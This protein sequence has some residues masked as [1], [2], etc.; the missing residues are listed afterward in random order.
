M[1]NWEKG[2]KGCIRKEQNCF[3]PWILLSPAHSI[4]Q[5]L[6]LNEL[7]HVNHLEKFWAYNK[8]S[9]Y[10][11]YYNYH[12]VTQV[13]QSE[14]HPNLLENSEVASLTFLPFTCS[15][16]LL[17]FSS[18]LMQLFPLFLL[19]NLGCTHLTWARVLLPPLPLIVSVLMELTLH[20]FGSETE[21]FKSELC[22]HSCAVLDFTQHHFSIL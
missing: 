3:L 13:L 1:K 5:L 8:Y 11:Y 21:R 7:V 10:I 20:R 14:V 12:F 18:H 19:S 22:V 17:D 6:G 16:H 2:L 9:E 15:S 4:N